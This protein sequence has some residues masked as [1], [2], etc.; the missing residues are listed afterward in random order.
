MCCVWNYIPFRH[1]LCTWNLTTETTMCLCQLFSPFDSKTWDSFFRRRMKFYF[2]HNSVTSLSFSSP[3]TKTAIEMELM[4]VSNDILFLNKLP[5]LKPSW[6]LWHQT[7]AAIS[8]HVDPSFVCLSVQSVMK[9]RR[10]PSRS[11][12]QRSGHAEHKRVNKI[13]RE[14]Q[15]NASDCDVTLTRTC[16]LFALTHR[17]KKHT[18]N[19]SDSLMRIISNYISYGN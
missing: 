8:L 5:L 6:Q 7:R 16:L 17:R 14:Y 10:M 12:R 9:M 1:S 3:K 15:R 18:E 19:S 11:H 2:W 4:N 13:T